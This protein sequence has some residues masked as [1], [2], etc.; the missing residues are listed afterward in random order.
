MKSQ[1]F[2]EKTFGE[3]RKLYEE[4]KKA[5]KETF[6]WKSQVV[7]TAYAKYVIEFVE[8][9]RPLWRKGLKR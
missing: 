7:L 1:E 4:A 8:G 9:E 3:F 5:E 2:I 6:T